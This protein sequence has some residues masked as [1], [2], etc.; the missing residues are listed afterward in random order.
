MKL[1]SNQALCCGTES[2]EILGTGDMGVKVGKMKQWHNLYACKNCKKVFYELADF[3]EVVQLFYSKKGSIEYQK[4]LVEKAKKIKENPNYYGVI[5]KMLKVH[6]FVPPRGGL[7]IGI[8]TLKGYR[9]FWLD[10]PLDSLKDIS[11][12]D[13]VAWGFDN[14]VEFDTSTIRHVYERQLRELKQEGK[15]A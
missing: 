6:V 15:I 10:Y 7:K 4:E 11:Y 13:L 5:T 3:G 1:G 12:Q 8:K 9:A 14:I 2:L